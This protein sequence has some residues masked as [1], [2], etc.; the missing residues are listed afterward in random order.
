MPPKSE[1]QQKRH[2]YILLLSQIKRNIQS[3]EWLN[4]WW[5]QAN[6]RQER[7]LSIFVCKQWTLT[8]FIARVEWGLMSDLNRLGTA[9]RNTVYSITAPVEKWLLWSNDSL[10]GLVRM[11]GQQCV[12]EEQCG[13]QCKWNWIKT[14]HHIRGYTST[15]CQCTLHHGVDNG[16][17]TELTEG[18]SLW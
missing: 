16:L 12:W 15:L 18:H 3:S 17:S 7:G 14:A 6:H 9:G 11:D 13:Q 5:Y 4:V 1:C 2:Q 10:Y 8:V